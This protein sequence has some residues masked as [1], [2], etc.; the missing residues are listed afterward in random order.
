MVFS[1]SETI[2]SNHKKQKKLTTSPITAITT[3]KTTSYRFMLKMVERKVPPTIP[4]R[5]CKSF[6]C[7]YCNS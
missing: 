2:V 5:N 7:I 3:V 6:C 4:E 1:Y